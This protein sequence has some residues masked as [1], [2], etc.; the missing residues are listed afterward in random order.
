MAESTNRAGRAENYRPTTPSIQGKTYFLG[1][2]VDEYENWPVLHNAVRDVQ[3]IVALLQSEYGV[4]AENVR[5]LLNEEATEANIIQA[6]EALAEQVTSEDSL[7]VYYA[8]H[9]HLNKLGRGFWVPVDAPHDQVFRYVRNTTIKDYIG[10][11]PSLHTLLISDSCFSGSLFSGRGRNSDLAA[12][13]L[14]RLPSRW[15]I[16]SGRHDEVVA[17][18]PTDGHSPFAESIIDVLQNNERPSITAGFL[19]NQIIEQTRSNY[20]Q[21]PDGG[22]L[23]NVG[24][25]RGQFVFRRQKGKAAEA[26]WT[27]IEGLAEEVI[28][29]I[30]QKK[31]AIR[32]Y[33]RD[34]PQGAHFQEAVS[35][36]Q[37]LEQK[38]QFLQVYDSEFGLV[39][40]VARNTPYKAEAKARLDQIRKAENL[41]HNQFVP[42]PIAT[43]ADNTRVVQKQVELNK[44]VPPAVQKTVAST[45]SSK[46][47]D[48]NHIK[49]IGG[50]VIAVVASTWLI[51]TDSFLNVGEFAIWS[52]IIAAFL[53]VAWSI[54]R[55]AVERRSYLHTWLL[56]FFAGMLFMFSVF[57]FEG[58]PTSYLIPFL[59]CTAGGTVAALPGLVRIFLLSRAK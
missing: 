36:G 57:Y 50:L 2:G 6:F 55:M 25:K 38:V 27:K 26:L 41:Q 7:L 49:Q 11:I 47:F 31:A 29:D 44:T 37:R 40:Y 19:V 8:G 56:G 32:Q 4:A 3:T 18:G 23:Q 53:Y 21:L 43:I 54:W 45:T 28:S 33:C 42:S 24:H 22:P 52:V 15:A 13:E 1:V 10:D 20:D 30:K 48:S 35:M 51:V 16:C 12:D 9:G 34:F 39:A 46:T 58:A 17:D 59:I 14:A 5:L